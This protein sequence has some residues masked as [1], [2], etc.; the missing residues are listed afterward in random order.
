MSPVHYK[1]GYINAQVDFELDHS[2]SETVRLNCVLISTA[3]TNELITFVSL[4]CIAAAGIAIVARPA[5]AQGANTT[6]PLTYP[7]GVVQGDGTQTCPSEEQREIVRNE[8]ENAT[9]RLLQESVVPLLQA[10]MTQLLTE[11]P[12][13]G[14]THSSVV[15]QLAGDV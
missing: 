14:S 4:V 6:L 7:G 13:G 3:K 5:V 1:A 8:V 15:K 11:H 2:G 10:N 9:R 12:C